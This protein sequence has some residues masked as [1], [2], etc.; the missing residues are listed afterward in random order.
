MEEKGKNRLRWGKQTILPAKA[1]PIEYQSLQFHEVD[2]FRCL[3]CAAYSICLDYANQ[4]RWESFTC[5]ACPY[6]KDGGIN[7]SIPIGSFGH[8]PE[9]PL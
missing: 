8:E 2:T 5:V 3:G 6:S 7:P 4:E 1:C 9:E